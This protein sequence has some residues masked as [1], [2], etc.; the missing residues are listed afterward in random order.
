MII[1]HRIR[2]VFSAVV[3]VCLFSPPALAATV[4]ASINANATPYPG[5][6][7]ENNVGW[8]Y[9]PT[10]SYT[11]TGIGTKFASLDEPAH[12]V[13]ES[14]YLGAPGNLTLVSSGS[15]VA[16]TNFTVPIFSP[17]ALLAGNQYFFAFGNVAGLGTNLSDDPGATNLGGLFYDFSPTGSPASFDSG[18]EGGVAAQPIV[19]FYGAL[20]SAVPEPGAWMMMIV[21]FGV[22]GVA[23][24]KVR[25][26]S[27]RYFDQKT[28]DA[29]ESRRFGK[30]M[31]ASTPY[32]GRNA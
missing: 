18:P 20:V 6:W 32:C 31:P 28:A 25:R 29:A 30:L 14:V 4:A 26:H 23:L 2:T 1:F 24:R 10:A 5:I 27:P 7:S 12:L 17:V 11:L 16:G 15:F 9:A 19:E 8:I 3:A 21:G 22:I 13:T